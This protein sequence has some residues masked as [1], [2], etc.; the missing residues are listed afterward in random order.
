MNDDDLASVGTFL[1][2]L[3]PARHDYNEP[4][5][6]VP[7]F[8]DTLAGRKRH[9]VAE[10]PDSGDIIRRQG[11]E[12]LIMPGNGRGRQSHG[13]IILSKGRTRKRASYQEAAQPNPR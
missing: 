10:P 11:W 4:W 8:H 12:H 7:C 3:N 13:S 2:D 5:G 9:S 1:A 6:D